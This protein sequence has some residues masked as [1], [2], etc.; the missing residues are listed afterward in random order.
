VKRLIVNADDLG[1]SAGVNRGIGETHERGIVTS[2]SLMVDRPAAEDGA[3]LARR[4]PRLSVGLHA[5]LDQR[6]ELTV[7][8]ESCAAELARQ[9]ERF[10]ELVGRQPTHIDSHHHA[11][12]DER[13]RDAFAAFADGHG[14]P[15]RERA[16]R[17]CAAYYGEAA[18]GVDSLL[19]ILGRLEHGDTELG[20][21]PGYAAGLQSRYTLDRESE[22]R[23]LTDPRVRA[24]LD[25]LGVQLIGWSEL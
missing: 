21:H 16:V 14:L 19:A 15:M 22:L 6:E 25:E 18:I 10:V 1:S 17:H 13:I 24:H 5:V 8:A 23:T 7:T 11:H 20:C 4:T 12:R 3:E 2:A 9:L